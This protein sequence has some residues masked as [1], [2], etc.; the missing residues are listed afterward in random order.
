MGSN[1]LN[2]ADK[3]IDLIFASDP[4]SLLE[5]VRSYLERGSLRPLSMNIVR[6][7]NSFCALVVTESK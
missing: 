6:E 2:K 5:R 3:K 7:C 1:F 4:K